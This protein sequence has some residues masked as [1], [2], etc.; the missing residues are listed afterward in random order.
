MRRRRDLGHD[1]GSVGGDPGLVDD[2]KILFG[3]EGMSRVS[4]ERRMRLTEVSITR[5]ELWTS[6]TAGV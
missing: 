2:G 5:S 1:D 4:R 3:R 6:G